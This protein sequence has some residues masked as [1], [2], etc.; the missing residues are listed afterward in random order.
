MRKKQ[1]ASR[2]AQSLIGTLES[3]EV[4]W[5]QLGYKAANLQAA[6]E[7]LAAAQ[8]QVVQSLKNFEMAKG[9]F[10]AEK[11]WTTSRPTKRKSIE[12]ILSR[13]KIYPTH[14]RDTRKQGH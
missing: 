8:A 9:A 1:A 11:A 4:F 5:F 2:R 13:E 10:M 14:R 7:E 12:P 6:V 3:R